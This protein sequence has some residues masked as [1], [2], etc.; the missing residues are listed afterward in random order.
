M[1]YQGLTH[2]TAS[3]VFSV[4]SSVRGAVS[5]EP[6]P[7]GGSRPASA[8]ILLHEPAASPGQAAV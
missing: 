8:E 7:D 3:L 6:V 2:S 1:N 4:S 5:E